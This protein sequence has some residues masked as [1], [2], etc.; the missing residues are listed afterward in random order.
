MNTG[1]T[2]PF[3]HERGRDTFC[4]IKNYPFQQR[5]RAVELTVSRG[6]SDISKFVLEVEELGGNEPPVTLWNS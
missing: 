3:A 6:V 5:R 1:A 4:T 2:R